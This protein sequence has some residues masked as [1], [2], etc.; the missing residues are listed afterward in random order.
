MN[1]VPELSGPRLTTLPFRSDILRTGEPAGTAP[2]E[3]SGTF[4]SVQAVSTPAM[5]AAPAAI[6]SRRS[7]K[8]GRLMGDSPGVALD[9]LLR[10]EAG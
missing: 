1:W 10:G 4:P 8:R 9:D 5:A 6:N 7:S 2:G 3:Y